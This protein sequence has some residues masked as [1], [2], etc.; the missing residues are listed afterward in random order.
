MRVLQ[1]TKQVRDCDMR[2]YRRHTT[3][4]I[5]VVG[6]DEPRVTTHRVPETWRA[7]RAAVMSKSTKLQES[8]ATHVHALSWRELYRGKWGSEDESRAY[9]AL[10][11]EAELP[12]ASDV[13]TMIPTSRDFRI[14]SG[15]MN[16]FTRYRLGQPAEVTATTEIGMLTARQAVRT[17]TVAY[18]V[19]KRRHR[20]ITQALESGAALA[21]MI[22]ALEPAGVLKDAD[23]C[24]TDMDLDI[25]LRDHS[26]KILA[27]DVTVVDEYSNVKNRVAKKL[28]GHRSKVSQEE[29]ERVA[30]EEH[31]EINKALN[32]PSNTAVNAKVAESL[33]QAVR[34]RV[35][36]AYSAGYFDAC[37]RAGMQARVVAL[38]PAGGWYQCAMSFLRDVRHSGDEAAAVGPQSEAVRFEHTHQSWQTTKY[39]TFMMHKAAAAMANATYGGVRAALASEARGNAGGRHVDGH[40]PSVVS[41]PKRTMR[42]D[43]GAATAAATGGS[44]GNGNGNGDTSASSTES[45]RDPRPAEPSAAATDKRAGESDEQHGCRMGMSHLLYGATGA[46]SE[47]DNATPTEQKVSKPT[48]IASATEQQSGDSTA[49]NATSTEG[50]DKRD[51]QRASTAEPAAGAATTQQELGAGEA[52]AASAGGG[53]GDAAADGTGAARQPAATTTTNRATAVTLADNLGPATKSK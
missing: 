35:R 44:S 48:T 29:A 4:T 38:S 34:N 26:G 33:Q 18:K 47:G 30:A 12:G 17:P 40:T 23:G 8:I 16:F 32:D 39:S 20:A 27:V 6:E 24:G 41:A 9:R 2:D 5:H 51:K 42:G 49:A 1:K 25:I 28:Y 52:A 37:A 19:R 45:S 21:S 14:A 43:K 10:L 50:G 7:M 11:E 36:G 46:S 13:F 15:A 22:V 3:R 53:S 31:K